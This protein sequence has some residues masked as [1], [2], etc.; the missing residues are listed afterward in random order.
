MGPRQADA[1][2]AA[3]IFAVAAIWGWTF[4]T[5]YVKTGHH[6]FFYQ[7]YF[8]PA[9]MVACG[10]GC[11]CSESQPPALRAFVMEQTARNSSDAVPP[12]LTVGTK[13]LY[14]RPWRSLTTIV[15]VA[16]R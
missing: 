2:V 7:S 9:V 14:Q 15:G 11:V 13:G 8:E 3:V 10:K 5:G 12:A 6:P 1:A 4:Y 16:W